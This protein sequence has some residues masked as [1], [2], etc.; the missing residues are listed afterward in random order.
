M[1]KKISS[2]DL[3][4]QEDIFKG[5]RDSAKQTIETM[6][7]LR[8]EVEGT[9][10]DLQKSIGGVKFDSAKAIERVVKA[11]QQSNKLT[12]EAIQIDKT[13]A[14]AEKVKIQSM[15]E[16][17]KLEQDRLKT[18]NQA[19][20]NQQQEAR[21]Q[22]RNNK[23]K[24]K[25]AKL[26]KDEANAYK[27]LEKRTRELKNRSKELGAQMLILEQSGKKNTKAYRDLSREYKQVTR[28]AKEGDAQLK[29]LDKTVG[30]NFRNVGN[31]K[32]ALGQARNA[33]GALGVAFGGAQ[34]VK[35]TV[36][37]IVDFDQAV[38]DLAAISGK[39]REELKGLNEQAREVGATTSFTASEVTN[40]QI[41]LAKLGFTT[42]QIK[43]ST[44]GVV[45]FA[46]ATGTDIPTS[47]KIA[48]SALRA[49]NLEAKEMDRVVSTL[50]VAT[51]KSALSA[52][53]YATSLS[54][55]APV[56]A[57]F[58]FSIE[59]T[60]TLLAKLAD[61]GF[62]A[63]SSATATR[64]IFLKLADANGDLAKAIGGPI[65]DIE[66]LD[67]ALTELVEVLGTGPE[68]LGNALELTDKRSVAAF[69]KFLANAGTMQ[70]FKES[71]T[72][73]NE[74]LKTMA[75]KR[76]ESVQGELTQLNSALQEQAIAFGE[77]I[78]AT[79]GMSAVLKF[80]R[81]NLA[82]IFSITGKLIRGFIV[83]KTT[84]MALRVAQ[85]LYNTDFKSMGLMMAKQIPMTRAY[86][87]EQ[88]A[89]ARA[90]R[91]GAKA[92]KGASTAVKGFGR[93]FASIGIFAIITG[94]TELAMAWWDVASGAKAARE[95]EEALKMQQE[96]LELS[97]STVIFLEDEAMKKLIEQKEKEMKLIDKK[98]RLQKLAA[99]NTKEE[100]EAELSGLR[101]K[102]ALMFEI[103][104]K[105]KGEIVDIEDKIKA[106]E[107]L[108]EEEKNRTK[109]VRKATKISKG[110]VPYAY[111]DFVE[112]A[113]DPVKVA[114]L[115]GKLQGYRG[116]LVS[117]VKAYDEF[118]EA[119]EDFKLKVKEFDKQV[120]KSTK[121][122]KT[123]TKTIK[124]ELSALA[125]YIRREKELMQQ[126]LEIEQ[127]R[128]LLKS[129]KEIEAEFKKQ[130]E[131]IEKTGEFD[132]NYL[133]QLIDEKL[134]KEQE[135]IDQRT[136]YELDALER[137]YKKIRDK[138][139]TELEAER[140]RLIKGAGTNEKKKAEI[141]ANFDA[142]MKVA[143][144]N[145]KLR[146][147]DRALEEII[148]VKN[149]EKDKEEA[150]QE[151]FDSAKSMNEE[152]TDNLESEIDKQIE[153]ERAKAQA[154]QDLAR[155][156]ADFFIEQSNRKIEAIDREIAEAQK[157]ADYFRELAAQG[158]IDAEKSLAEQQRI[159]NEANKKKLR[160]EKRQA[161]I[162]LAESVFN[163]YNQ[164][165]QQD[166]VADPLAETIRDSTL[167]LNFINSLQIPAFMDGTEDTGTNGQG[168]DGKG[169]FH[170]ILHP[171]ERV[172]PK[173]MNDKIGDLSNE[174]LT[175]LALNYHNKQHMEGAY[176]TASALELSV[177]VS[178]LKGIKNEI[179]N[180][181]ETNIAMGEI[182]SSLVE[183][184]NTR[185]QG[186][187]IVYNRFKIRK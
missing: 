163:T 138:E 23:Q 82:L 140:D 21:I 164:K 57:T 51:T 75:Q 106:T 84:L 151:S 30:D 143:D 161:R 61:A 142:K 126:I 33:L 10:K 113:T 76:M 108:L 184:V 111:K 48:G 1:A 38:A 32:D 128:D 105:S 25:A 177:L 85:R 141:R 73:V 94:V 168:V 70:E 43:A 67:F 2:K 17:E 120:S 66:D 36:S 185:K 107:V 12:K 155:Q 187:S 11:Q 31:Y 100:Q 114:D 91:D 92:T 165:L 167:L 81:E 20:R 170:A 65:R 19:V 44:D 169:G 124:T 178:E 117:S 4:A 18:Q 90:N 172:I 146:Q 47:A 71:I 96:M 14:Q 86:K 15:R 3:F 174:A 16:L 183:V 116:A 135:Y 24:Q 144:A 171:N 175:E 68:G 37:T 181:P 42:E 79:E 53:M 45:A 153:L 50:G 34:I 9:A 119:Y 103:Q 182:T 7:R 150:R 6:N 13:K 102:R 93:A 63:S 115:T 129:D 54:T 159:I 62:D 28:S 60:T 160:E 133:N 88:I 154:L 49:F 97:K 118:G 101:Q 5:I 166:D 122:S 137:K 130:I 149:G 78:M 27:Q 46:Q 95:A 55:V 156:V 109:I 56:A 59:D 29:K 35:G 52:E 104:Q 80:L 121:G 99:K 77:S 123:R 136:M 8:K 41:E 176:Q 147:R 39:T 145:E 40:A 162:R 110:G 173:V 139:V 134:E 26:A 98:V 148:I 179:K 180:K 72:D 132:A 87:M 157:Q 64:N 186:N 22:E 131:N 74:E 89:L 112:D 125:T 158:N 152:L 127:D 83:Y 69:T 58:G